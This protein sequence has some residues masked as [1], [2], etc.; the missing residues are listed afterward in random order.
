MRVLSSSLRRR[1]ALTYEHRLPPSR[2]SMIK[3]MRFGVSTASYMRA[4]RGWDTCSMILISLWTRF[5]CA[6][7]FNLDLS[8]VLMATLEPVKRC[9]AARTL[10]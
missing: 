8:Y 6:G 4:M 3:C 2:H 7:S 1:L 9:H 5:Q 10:P